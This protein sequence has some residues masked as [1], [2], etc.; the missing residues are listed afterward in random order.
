MG[1]EHEARC[2]RMSL[3]A[4]LHVAAAS[5]G[6]AVA[7]S[8]LLLGLPLAL[9]AWG[10]AEA[11]FVFV[12]LSR[13]ATL[14]Y[15]PIKHR[16]VGVGGWV[17]MRRHTRCCGRLHDWSMVSCFP[18]TPPH[19]PTPP[20]TH[21]PL[22]HDPVAAFNRTMAHLVRQDADIRSFLSI[23]FHGAPFASIKRGNVLD[24]LAYAFW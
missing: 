23:W 22:S 20:T 14:S 16:W 9:L 1:S 19:H 13:W 12:Y 7:C 21:R 18:L 17:R 5:V 4:L 11:V 3:R 8:P 24:L 6:L 2:M 15:Q 10:A